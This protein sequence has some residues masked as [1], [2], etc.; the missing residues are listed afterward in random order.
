MAIEIVSFPINSM[1][2][3][4]SYVSSP[5]GKSFV[6][7]LVNPGDF[8]PTLQK[9]DESWKGWIMD[10]SIVRG[11]WEYTSDIFGISMGYY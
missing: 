11:E 3:F 6:W 4:H 2:I 7:W 9:K 8:S 5:E 1:V 10:E